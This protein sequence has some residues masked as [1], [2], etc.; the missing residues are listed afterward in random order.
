MGFYALVRY[1]VFSFPF[2]LNNLDSRMVDLIMFPFLNQEQGIG[3]LL[4]KSKSA[5][6][7]SIL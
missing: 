4:G 2:L 6:A 5:M 3:A 7:Y 1:A